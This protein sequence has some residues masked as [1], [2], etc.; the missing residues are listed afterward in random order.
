MI[1]L[2]TLPPDEA[3]A[4]LTRLAG[5]PGLSAGDPGV[6]ESTRLCG[7]LPLAIGML[8][9]QLHQHPAWSTAGLAAGLAAARD[10]LELMRAED[11]SVA[12]AFDLS[13]QE[14]PAGQQQVLEQ[15]R[16]MGDRSGQANVRN[17]LGLL[18]QQAGDYPAAAASHQQALEVFRDLGDRFGEAET[19]NSLGE[20]LLRSSTREQARGHH[21]QALAIARGLGTPRE[22]ARA[23]EGI[24]RCHIQDGNR[25][26][27]AAK[28]RQALAIYQRIG[29][30]DALRVQETLR[31]CS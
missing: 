4:L 8:A 12:A 9:R 16:G 28:L 30:P 6:G 24:G 3:A 27:G 1:S 2:D 11:L 18:Q 10:R 17:E 23:L 31:G 20:L 13:Y 29:T 19:L 22:E 14:L 26:E 25:G 15:F 7:Y 21:T 5:R